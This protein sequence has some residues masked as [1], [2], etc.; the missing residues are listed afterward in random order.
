M[1][2]AAAEVTCPVRR[3]EVQHREGDEARDGGDEGDQGAPAREAAGKQHRRRDGGPGAHED[4]AAHPG[5]DPGRALDH[6]QHRAGSDHRRRGARP[7]RD[8]S[9]RAGAGPREVQRARGGGEDQHRQ[10]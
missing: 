6:G 10:P 1:Q 7:R 4:H 3:E 5:A 8:R 2:D 9:G